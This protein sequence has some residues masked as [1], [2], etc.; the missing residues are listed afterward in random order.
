MVV[1]PLGTSELPRHRG[2]SSSTS[3]GLTAEMMSESGAVIVMHVLRDE[4]HPRRQRAAMQQ[5]LVGAP[6]ER[7]ALDVL[8]GYIALHTLREQVYFNCC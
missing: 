7:L 8:H 6:M 5:Y 3:I 2:V 1:Q 4:V